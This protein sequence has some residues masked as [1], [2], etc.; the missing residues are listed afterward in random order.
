MNDK[1]EFS[2]TVDN[3]AFLNDLIGFFNLRGKTKNN[4]KYANIAKFLNSAECSIES[5]RRFASRKNVFQAILIIKLPSEIIDKIDQK[6]GLNSFKATIQYWV[7]D[8]LD[9][10]I[11]YQITSTDTQILPS[12]LLD[13]NS[14]IRSQGNLKP[15]INLQDISF[16]PNDLLEKGE[17]M[18]EVYRILFL[19]ENSLRYLI[20]EVA[21]RKYGDSFI[22]LLN[23]SSS[24]RKRIKDRTE[25]EK[26]NKWIP[27]RGT[28]DI[29]YVDFKDLG[30]LIQNNW[31][32]FK[33]Y[34]PDILFITGKL[35]DISKYRNLIAHNSYITETDYNILV[36]YYNIIL[37]Q[38]KTKF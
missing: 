35:S 23:I 38:I 4:S 16:L 17:K 1:S 32:I 24:I 18:A 11:G 2:Y 20:E 27:L 8:V 26:R 19:L 10:N 36:S 3:K 34:F 5:T 13:K 30:N 6:V 21:K 29:F 9:K 15:D 25:E 12:H 22:D 14:S 37:R 31:E 33:D 28:S 7:D